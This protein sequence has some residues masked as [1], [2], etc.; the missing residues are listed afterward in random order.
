MTKEA[1]SIRFARL[2]DKLE[3]EE[4]IDNL[5]DRRRK[6]LLFCGDYLSEDELESYSSI[7]TAYKIARVRYVKEVLYDINP[8]LA[9]RILDGKKIPISNIFQNIDY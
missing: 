1:I 5:C 9:E 3:D 6:E 7:D 4:Y 8:T 2:K